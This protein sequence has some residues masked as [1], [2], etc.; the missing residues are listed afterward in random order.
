MNRKEEITKE[1]ETLEDN[2]RRLRYEYDTIIRNE[3][4][5]NIGDTFIELTRITP[6]YSKVVKFSNNGSS[7]I[8]IRVTNTSIARVITTYKDLMGGDVDK[9]AEDEFEK[10]YNITLE[11]INKNNS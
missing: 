3:K 8:I 2:I 11:N 9:C 7:I 5:V 1:I 6:I 4:P 10:Q